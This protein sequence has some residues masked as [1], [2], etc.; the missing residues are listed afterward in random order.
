MVEVRAT[1]AR[2]LR[3]EPA[4]LETTMAVLLEARRAFK[5]TP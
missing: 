4:S 5:P 3:C 2:C 1:S